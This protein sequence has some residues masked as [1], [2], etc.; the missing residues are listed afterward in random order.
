MPLARILTFDPGDAADFAEQ[1]QQLGF[2]VEIMNPNEQALA[3]A[4]LEIEFAICDQQQVLG[5]ASAIAAQLQAQVVVFPGSIPPLPKPIPIQEHYE[6]AEPPDISQNAPERIMEQAAYQGIHEDAD[7]SPANET[8]ED[9]VFSRL[10]ERLRAGQQRLRMALAA[11]TARLKTA[12]SSAGNAVGKQAGTLLQGLKSQI[13]GAR[14]AG[15]RQLAE[16]RHKRAEA[17]QRAAALRLERQREAELAASTKEQE[18][19]NHEALAAAAAQ[20]ELQR[21]QAMKEELL[22]EVERLRLEAKQQAAN[23]VKAE[24][25]RQEPGL[26][27][28]RPIIQKVI[29]VVRHGNGQLRG[30]LAGA[31][32]AIFLFLVGMVWANFHAIT[33][34]SHN[35]MS[36]SVEQQVPFGAA[37]VHGA[38]GVTITP[39]PVSSDDT[40]PP[41]AP[42]SRQAKP[43]PAISNAPIA[44]PDSEWHHFQRA[45]SDSDNGDDSTAPDVVVRHFAPP[46]RQPTQTA[47]QR[48]SIKR[49]SDE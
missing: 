33:P 42:P 39:R 14:A 2:Q 7:F 8:Q 35:L 17:A 22:A 32:T 11:I 46:R 45:S 19:Q 1:L 18:R 31:G 48:A 15:Q 23:L 25:Q 20:G 30:A 4:D 29:N 5:R 21:L 10:A 12:V 49:Y 6:P 16:M 43:H 9:A 24:G 27:A 47:Q 44:K 13:A 3:P 40:P 28:R 26:P 37:T 36:G 34:V 41:Q 38:P